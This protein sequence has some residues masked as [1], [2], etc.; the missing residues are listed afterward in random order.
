MKCFYIQDPMPQLLKLMD[1]L[2]QRLL[3]RPRH[4][5]ALPERVYQLAQG[6]LS[7]KELEYIG[8]ARRGGLRERCDHLADVILTR[9][10][11]HY[12]VRQTGGSALERVR[13]L[14]RTLIERNGKPSANSK[15]AAQAHS[16]MEDL[17]FVTQLFSYPGNYLRDKLTLERLAETLDKLEEDLLQTDYP[18]IRGTRRVIV[19]F[20][21]P[22][23][24]ANERHKKEVVPQLTRTLQERVQG[25]L[26]KL[27]EQH[28]T[29]LT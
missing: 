12:G 25:M 19:R 9:Q 24:I 28:S 22:V 17:F 27:N 10:E 2:E 18:G 21:E 6:V 16:D 8:K 14:R 11:H 1:R 4:G 23:P 26:D 29:L 15:D 20:G 7:L 13:D 3:W 5:L